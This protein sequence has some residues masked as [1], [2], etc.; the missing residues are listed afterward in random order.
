[1][2]H[3]DPKEVIHKTDIIYK[4]NQQEKTEIQMENAKIDELRVR[5]EQERNRN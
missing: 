2:H 5:E 4:T 1:V 3:H